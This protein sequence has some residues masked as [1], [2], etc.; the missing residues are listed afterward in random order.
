M[1]ESQRRKA[2]LKVSKTG[3]ENLTEA[4]KDNVVLDYAG[5]PV[6]ELDGPQRRR[7][8]DLIELYVDNMDDGHAKVKMEEVQAHLARTRFAWIGDTTRAPSST[9]A[10][11]AP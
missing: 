4:W 8:L 2:I 3:D 5:I 10:F 7:L 11:T 6:S 1:S 9:T